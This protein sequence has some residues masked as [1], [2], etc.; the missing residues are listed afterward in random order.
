[1]DWYTLPYTV[2]RGYVRMWWE[3]E[4]ESLLTKEAEGFRSPSL[5]RQAV[6]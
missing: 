1:M 5:S 4:N 2:F 6:F 3:R